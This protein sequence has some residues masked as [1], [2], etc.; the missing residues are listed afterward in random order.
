MAPCTL[1]IQL[2]YPDAQIPVRATPDSAGL[3]LFSYEDMIIIQPRSNRVIDTGISVAIT[4]KC[5]GRIAPRSGL[6][7][8]NNLFVNAGVIDKNYRGVVKVVLYNG[9]VDEYIVKKGD[10]IAQLIIEKIK[11]PEVVVCDTL[12]ETVRGEGGFG[13]TGTSVVNLPTAA[14]TSQQSK[15]NYT[16]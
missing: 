6:A 7:Y 3:D 15:L 10:R 11:Y 12:E 14:P 1:R 8:K 13:S 9:S 16:I 2:N 4:G 5:Y